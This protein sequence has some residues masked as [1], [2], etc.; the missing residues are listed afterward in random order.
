M[1]F[2]QYHKHVSNQQG[3]S[4][5]R[6]IEL[7]EELKVNHGVRRIILNRLA[8]SREVYLLEVYTK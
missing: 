5:R 8:D 2:K 6:L 1:S 3:L 7:L 4:F